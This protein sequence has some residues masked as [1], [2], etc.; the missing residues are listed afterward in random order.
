VRHSSRST[1]GLILRTIAERTGILGRLVVGIIGMV[2][3]VAVFF[4]VPVLVIDKESPFD[5]I[6]DL[7]PDAQEDLGRADHPRY[8]I[9]P[10]LRWSRFYSS[11]PW[12]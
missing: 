9:V 12:L 7:N 10:R 6:K 5:A 3:N 4:V 1:V 11:F 2:W 8:R